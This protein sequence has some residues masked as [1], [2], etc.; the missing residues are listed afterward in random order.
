VSR[1]ALVTEDG[2]RLVAVARYDRSP[3]TGEAEVAFVVADRYQHHGIGMILLE[4]LAD[5]ARQNG[6]SVFT[7]QT[8]LENRD[9]IRVFMDS[10]FSVRTTLEQG[11]VGVRFPIEPDD[12][13]R[14]A[15][16]ARAARIRDR[17]ASPSGSSPC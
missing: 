6:I 9:M 13:S 17:L 15:R 11:V 10:G 1:L 3:E 2:T 4:H 12:A 7:A 16:A 8:L 5:A 14:A